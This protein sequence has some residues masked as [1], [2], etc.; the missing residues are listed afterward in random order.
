M[1]DVTTIGIDIAK[2][3][4]Q[5]Y[6]AGGSGNR[7][8]SRRLSRKQFLSYMEKQPRCLVGMEACGSAHYWGR[9]LRELGFEVKLMAPQFVKPYV[10]GNKTDSKDAQAICEAVGRAS[11]RFVP[12]KSE[13]QQSQNFRHRLRSR[14][15]GARTALTNQLR[16]FL[17]E[18]GLVF[19]KGQASLHKRL[20]EILEDGENGLPR[21]TRELLSQMYEELCA[22][23][24]RI[25]RQTQTI[26]RQAN[27][28]LMSRLLQTI[29]GIG[30]LTSSALSASIGDATAFGKGREVS[31]WLGLTPKVVASGERIHLGR[32]TKRGDRYLR[33]L[34][35]HGARAVLRVAH[36]KTDAYHRWVVKLSERVGRHKAIVAIANKNARIAWAVLTQQQ[37]FQTD[38]ACA[39]VG[40]G[41]T[42]VLCG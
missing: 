30:A 17:Y 16:G 11:M 32:I 36:R 10:K 31:A 5:I 21:D 4:F 29:P 23:D 9:A 12:L 35:I 8:L 34:L 3:V 25:A 6:G 37:P 24:E 13:S 22:L 1:N 33:M 41:D 14:L 2:N 15:V 7:V 40:S 26:E 27:E 38:K 20:P 19:A 39:A 18:F 42:A 28:S